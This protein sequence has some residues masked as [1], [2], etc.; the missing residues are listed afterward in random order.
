MFISEECPVKELKTASGR[1]TTVSCPLFLKEQIE[2][3]SDKYDWTVFI[4]QNL[5]LNFLVM[6]TNK[7]YQYLFQ[8]KHL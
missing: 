5:L 7:W 3:V 4:N 8:F 6:S 1:K 2:E